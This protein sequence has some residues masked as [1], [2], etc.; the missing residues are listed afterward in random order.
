MEVLQTKCSD[1]MSLAVKQ[2]ETQATKDETGVP[3]SGA[4]DKQ[5]L[6]AD[7]LRLSRVH[8]RVVP[9]QGDPDPNRDLS[10]TPSRSPYTEPS[11]TSTKHGR[12]WRC[13]WC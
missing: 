12:A 9:G 2:I 11:L 4:P 6:H 8:R 3:A 10:R 5:G 1:A 13:S 7:L